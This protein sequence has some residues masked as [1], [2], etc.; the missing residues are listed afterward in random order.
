ML[1]YP[2][3]LNGNVLLRFPCGRDKRPLTTHGFHDATN[4]SGILTEGGDGGRRPYAACQPARCPISTLSTSILATV[5]TNGT[6][7]TTP[8]CHAPALIKPPAAGFI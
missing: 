8:V 2:P 1:L 5:G 7:E 3:A 6:M 4:D